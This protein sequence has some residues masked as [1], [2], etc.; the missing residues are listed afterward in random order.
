M[1]ISLKEDILKAVGESKK[2][3]DIRAELETVINE[4]VVIE[5][6]TENLVGQL[7]IKDMESVNNI[8]KALLLNNYRIELETINKPFPRETTI[9]HFEISI[10]KDS[11]E[12]EN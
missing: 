11:L 3:S 10:Y 5:F 1:S 4:E 7:I 2:L 12:K 6:E 8:T 9:D